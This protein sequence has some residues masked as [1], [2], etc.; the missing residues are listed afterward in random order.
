MIGYK[1]R[2][3]SSAYPDFRLQQSPSRRNILFFSVLV[4][5]LS[6]AFFRAI[7]TSAHSLQE[8]ASAPLAV[9]N[10]HSCA[11]SF[12]FS[13]FFNLLILCLTPAGRRLS[14][15]AICVHVI[16]SASMLRIISSSAS[17]YGLVNA[18][19]ALP[20]RLCSS[21]PSQLKSKKNELC[22]ATS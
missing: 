16:P 2:S 20:L 18:L 4:L 1:R 17:V 14:C 22:F 15:A 11:H 7:N 9:S 19:F 8:R 3:A 12:S 10:P 21:L 5:R 13:R 6:L